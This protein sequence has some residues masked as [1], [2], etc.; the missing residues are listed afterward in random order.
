MDNLAALLQERSQINDRLSKLL[1]GSTEIRESE[2]KKY[3]YVHYRDGGVLRSKYA[4]EY[5]QELVNLVIANSALARG[6]KKRVRNIQ[7]ALDETGYVEGT[8]DSKVGVN[9][10]LARRNLVD[11]IYKQS[12]L[13]GVATT[14]SDTE[15]L[16]NGGMVKNMTVEDVGKVV[17]LKHAWEFI[18]NDGVIQYPSNYPILCQINAVVQEGFSYTAGKVRNV[19]VSIGGCSYMLPVPLENQVSEELRAIMVGPDV[20]ETSIEALLY[21]MKRQIFLDGN[22][23]TAVIFANHHLIQSGKGLIVIPAESVPEFKKLLI[24]FYE[25]DEKAGIVAFLKEKCLTRL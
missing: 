20:V 23:R 1:Y 5:S 15:T 22:K 21:V 25:T 12:V 11:S 8:I 17:N 19:P 2:G 7:K 18:L 24:R 6:Y 3:L 9:I 13:E 14:Y 10:D 16:V 4:G